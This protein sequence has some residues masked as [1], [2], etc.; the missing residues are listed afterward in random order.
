MAGWVVGR[1]SD[2]PWVV[3]AAYG[4]SSSTV[5]SSWAISSGKNGQPPD[6]PM[7]SPTGISLRATRWNLSSRRVHTNASVRP[8][9][10]MPHPLY[11]SAVNARSRVEAQLREDLEQRRLL[12]H[13]E[14]LG[15]VDEAFGLLARRWCHPYEA[16]SAR[17]TRDRHG[18]KLTRAAFTWAHCAG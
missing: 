18:V 2:Q 3:A 10:L 9:K 4:A 8:L 12:I 15:S 1:R 16:T 5:S 13:R 7:S 6:V 11:A 17:C 14:Q